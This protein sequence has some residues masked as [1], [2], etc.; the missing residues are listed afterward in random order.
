[1]HFSCIFN[2]NETQMRISKSHTHNKQRE[3]FAAISAAKHGL[4]FVDFFMLYLSMIF[5]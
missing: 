2:L 5:T 4:L 1:M 3:Q